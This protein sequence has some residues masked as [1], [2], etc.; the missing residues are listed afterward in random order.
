VK[1][2]APPRGVTED[3]PSRGVTEDAPP[4]EV[5][6]DAPPGD[7]TAPAPPGGAT[8]EDLHALAHR[9]LAAP[10]PVRLVAVDGPAGSGKSTFARD[11]ARALGRAPVVDLDDF[12]AWTDLETWWPRLEAEVVRPLLAGRPARWAVRDWHGDPHGTATLGHRSAPPHPA[13][14]LDGVSSSRAALAPRLALAVWVEAAPEER[15]R[16]GVARDGEAMRAEWEAWQ[17][18]EARFFAADGARGRAAVRLRT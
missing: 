13:V 12:F 1:E 10:G 3:G 5:A 14:V 11:L 17:A 2:D 9:V 6:E 7:V 18:L 8:Q 4:R 16:R 15:L